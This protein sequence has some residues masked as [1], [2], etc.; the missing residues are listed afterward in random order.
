MITRQQI[1]EIARTYP[2]EIHCL[3]K[4]SFEEQLEKHLCKYFKIPY[5]KPKEIK[6]D[7]KQT[8]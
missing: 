6:K 5:E 2:D 1:K 8:K 4:S 3:P 7:D